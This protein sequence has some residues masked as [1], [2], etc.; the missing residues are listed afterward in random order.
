MTTRVYV[1]IALLD[2]IVRPLYTV[3]LP[4]GRNESLDLF[5]GLTRVCAVLMGSDQWTA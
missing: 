4:R 5:R 2:S 1:Q 3:N